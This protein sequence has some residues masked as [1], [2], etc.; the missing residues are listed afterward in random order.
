MIDRTDDSQL[1]KEATPQQYQRSVQSVTNATTTSQKQ[2]TASSRTSNALHNIT[3]STP[4]TPGFQLPF[5]SM[6]KKEDKVNLICNKMQQTFQRHD[7]EK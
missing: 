6:E 5:L 2:T 7:P 1:K 3:Q 4:T